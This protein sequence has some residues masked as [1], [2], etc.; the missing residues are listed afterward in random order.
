MR[1]TLLPQVL[2]NVAAM[3]S[4]AIAVVQGDRCISFGQL[5]TQANALCGYFQQRIQPGD[6]VALLLDNC[7]EYIACC[8][9]IWRAGGVVVGLNTALKP[10]EL[11]RLIAHCSAQ[12]LILG[13]PWQALRALLPDSVTYIAVVESSAM[14]GDAHLADI[15]SA[16]EP[17]NAVTI[18]AS[19]PA[20]VIYTS[21]TTGHPKGVM[22]SHGNLAANIASICN[23][24]ALCSNDIAMCVLPFFYAYGNSVLHSHLASGSTLVLENSFAYPHRV[25]ESMQQQRVTTFYGVPSTYYLLLA[26]TTLEN[27]DLSALRFVAQA[28]GPMAKDKLCLVRERLPQAHFIVMYGQTEACARLTY[29]P[30]DCLDLKIGSVGKAIPG[31][32]LAVLNDQGAPVA[33]QQVGEVCVR[34]ANIMQG[35]LHDTVKTQKVLRAGWLHTGDLGYLDSEGFLFIEGRNSEMIKT[36]AYRVCPLEIEELIAQHN[37]V[38]EVAVVAADDDVLGAIIKAC[39]V[40]G[41][42]DTPQTQLKQQILRLCK[43]ELPLYKIPKQLVFLPSLPKTASGKIQKHLL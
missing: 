15:V 11:Q 8:Y 21:G 31:V 18:H 7:M 6:C 17:C 28:G 26:R 4:D 27:Y 36:G 5:N 39:V 25:L 40:L 24:L 22:L 43:T 2:E 33:P 10:K 32:E 29:L 23:Y 13:K 30:V 42:I 38:A 34:G 12:Y 3:Q 1:V 41:K 37:A 35:Y 9:A 20:M 19:S 16:S 14:D